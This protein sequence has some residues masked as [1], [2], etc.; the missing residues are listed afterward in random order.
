MLI[1]TKPSSP[2]ILLAEW[3]WICRFLEQNRFFGSTEVSAFTKHLLCGWSALHG[4]QPGS[5]WNRHVQLGL[6]VSPGM[7]NRWIRY[8]S[9]YP[10][11]GQATALLIEKLGGIL[12]VRKLGFWGVNLKFLILEYVLLNKPRTNK[13]M[14]YWELRYTWAQVPCILRF[15]MI[16]S[17][18]A[19][20]TG[21]WGWGQTLRTK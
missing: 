21:F 3:R 10:Y 16:E 19:F 4:E 15:L 9:L 1:K 5:F 12:E 18:S 8:I 20:H 6:F 11:M 14:M 13:A 2:L 7:K 17:V